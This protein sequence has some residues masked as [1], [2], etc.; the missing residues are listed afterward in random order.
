MVLRALYLSQHLLDMLRVA[1]PD[2]SVLQPWKVEFEHLSML[3]VQL[4]HQLVSPGLV[5]RTY[6]SQP[7]PNSGCGHLL[8][9][10]EANLRG[11]AGQA[12]HKNTAATCPGCHCQCF[13]Q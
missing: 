10:F 1:S 7:V 2:L 6:E 8:K 13:A 12:S 11:T 4:L 9:W 5:A 3:S